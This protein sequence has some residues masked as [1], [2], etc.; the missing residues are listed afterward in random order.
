MK[1]FISVDENNKVTSVLYSET[2]Q[3]GFLPVKSP[4]LENSDDGM[5]LF[6]NHDTE[7]CF[8]SDN[9][10][11]EKEVLQVLTEENESLKSRMSSLE[12]TIM[13]LTMM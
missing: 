7:E 11:A 10:S 9:P 3:Q 13:F 1:T 6:Y 8:F 2:P 4:I 12:D 5:T